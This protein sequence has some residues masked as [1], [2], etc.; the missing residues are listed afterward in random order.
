MKLLLER[1]G[2]DSDD[3]VHTLCAEVLEMLE[4]DEAAT[5]WWKQ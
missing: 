5:A 2:T 4:T 1:K 3:R